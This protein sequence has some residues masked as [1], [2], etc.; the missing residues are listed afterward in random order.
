[1]LTF[2]LD[3]IRNTI[4]RVSS[5]ALRVQ[6]S[7]NA[8]P[9]TPGFRCSYEIYHYFLRIITIFQVWYIVDLIATR[10]THTSRMEYL[11]VIGGYRI[12]PVKRNTKYDVIQ[13]ISA[14]A[15]SVVTSLRG[16]QAAILLQKL[17]SKLHKLTADK[18][19]RRL[20]K[21]ALSYA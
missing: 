4:R 17:T 20:T 3:W 9:S 15:S 5:T 12:T 8:S 14:D 6:W 10:N 1:M 11:T 16:W 18:K 7:F 13:Y 21:S 19:N 2:L